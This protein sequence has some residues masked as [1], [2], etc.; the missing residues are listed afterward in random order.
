M[1]SKNFNY[2]FNKTT[3]RLIIFIKLNYYIKYFYI[4]IS[5]NIYMFCVVIFI[6]FY[7]SFYEVINFE[8]DMTK[9]NYKV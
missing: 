1:Q 6:F 9:Q 2:K 8:F 7:I 5:M 4:I 3:L